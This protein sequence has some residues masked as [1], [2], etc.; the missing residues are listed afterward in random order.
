MVVAIESNDGSVLSNVL[1]YGCTMPRGSDRTVH[2][3]QAGTQLQL[4]Q[5]FAQHHWLVD[6]GRHE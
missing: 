2:Y 3:G 4:L 6:G 5:Y 1:Q